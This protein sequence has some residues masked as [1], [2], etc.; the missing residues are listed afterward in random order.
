MEGLKTVNMKRMARLREIVQRCPN[1]RKQN[2]RREDDAESLQG[3]WQVGFSGRYRGLGTTPAGD[4]RRTK[5]HLKLLPCGNLLLD[6][7]DELKAVPRDELVGTATSGLMVRCITVHDVVAER[8]FEFLTNVLE[9][10]VL[11]GVLAQFYRMRW[12]IEKSFDEVKNK[13]GEKKAR[14][15][16]ATAKSMQAQFICLSVNLLQLLDHELGQQGIR[17]EPEE[18]RRAARSKLAWEVATK[19][20]AV[21]PKTRRL[22]QRITQHSVKLIR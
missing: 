2:D 6:R 15:T 18:K 16:S 11:S 3:R 14:A 9:S 12:E 10:A 22:M 4:P 20:K 8:C 17:N 19:A 13:L 5:T 1:N 21:P 7:G